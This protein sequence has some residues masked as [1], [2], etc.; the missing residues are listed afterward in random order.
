MIPM[1]TNLDEVI[2]VKAIIEDIKKELLI[3]KI[4]FKTDIPLGVMIEVPSAALIVD[5]LLDHVDFISIGTNDL[6]QYLLAVDRVN[7]YVSSM[8]DPFHPAVLRIINL[9]VNTVHKKGKKVSVCGEMASDPLGALALLALG[10]DSLSVP[11]KLFLKIR[12]HIRNINYEKLIKLSTKILN[13][14]DSSRVIEILE[15]EMVYEFK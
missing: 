11:L 5:Y 14:S 9:I 7:Q 6:I 2:Q 10:V 8:Y 1:V 3:N 15:K 12:Q 13:E 4:A